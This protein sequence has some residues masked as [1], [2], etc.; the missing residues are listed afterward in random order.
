MSIGIANIHF[1]S[2]KNGNNLQ[3]MK[4]TDSDLDH[5]EYTDFQFEYL[6]KNQLNELIVYVTTKTGYILEILYDDKRI[7]NIHHL[8]KKNSSFTISTL[9][10]TKHFSI[11]GSYDGYIRIWSKDFSQIHIEAKYDQSISNLISSYDQTRILISTI[12]GSINILNL[13]T[14]EH[15]NLMRTHMKSITDIDY[16][17]TRKQMITVGQDGT[18][19]IWCFR[20]GKQL[21][22]FISEK[23]VP[24][25]VTYIP[26][27]QLFACGF[28]D[29]TIK[30]FDINTSI[31]LHELKYE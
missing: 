26:N 31:I 4:I 21:S 5:F 1:W 24:L 9:T 15:L 19:R 8:S 3:S 18:I 13:V 7:I 10:C 17:D 30:I 20:T 14:K 28:N 2:I 16:D 6:S 27:K 29:G 23:D 11:T 22:E 25:I 12:S